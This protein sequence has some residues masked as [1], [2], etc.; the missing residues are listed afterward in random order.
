MAMIT[1]TA[2]VAAI[3]SEGQLWLETQRKAVCDS[4]AVQNGC[5][6]GVLSKMFNARPAR[7]RVQNTLGAIV[8]DE[9]V[10][11][12]DDGQLVRASFAAYL[13]PLAWMFVGALAG[14]M[15]AGTLQWEQ[16]DGVSALGGLLGLAAGFL[17]LRRYAHRAL[18]EPRLVGF[19]G[20]EDAGGAGT[21]A[22]IAVKD[23][24]GQRCVS[25]ADRH[26]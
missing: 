11:G 22:R 7:I 25:A 17:G 13:M 20:S 3:D 2:R 4:C 19:A 18:Q 23:V 14:G 8:G 5:G 12:I 26:R 9:V 10:V 16:A 6:S 24:G 1:E 21:T 15:L